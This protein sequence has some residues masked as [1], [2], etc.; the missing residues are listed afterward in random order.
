MDNELWE[1]KQIE[2][3]E[4]DP[5]LVMQELDDNYPLQGRDNQDSEEYPFEAEER[6]RW[7]EE[8]EEAKPKYFKMIAEGEERGYFRQTVSQ[9]I[10]ESSAAKGK[11]R[12]M[13]TKMK[14][15]EKRKA[16]MR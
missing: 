1:A 7:Q 6:V 4:H 16:K 15:V 2:A 3:W 11:K 14:E 9:M 8:E 10:E 12:E 13:E 5:W